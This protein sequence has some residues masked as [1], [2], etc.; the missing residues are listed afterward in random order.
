[1]KKVFTNSI[2]KRCLPYVLSALLL[3]LSY[4]SYPYIR[5]EALAW[6]WMAPMLFALKDVRSFPRFLRNVYLTLLCVAVTGM[7]WLAFS[8]LVGTLLL[9]LIFPVILSVP[10]VVFYFVRQNLGWRVALLSLPFVWTAWDWLYLQT[11]GSL[12]WVPIGVTQSNLYW[13]VQYVDIT[14]VWGISFW[15]VLF[16]VLVILAVDD[17]RLRKAEFRDSGVGRRLL[18][19][20]LLTVFVIM[21]V[22][23]LSYSAFAF[24]KYARASS[25]NHKEISLLMVQPNVNSWDKLDPS[26]HAAVLARTLT[27]T[28][29]ALARMTMPPDLIIWPETAIPGVL[30]ENHEARGKVS[31]SITRWQ[32][33]LL[34]GLLDRQSSDSFS[35]NK[36][37]LNQGRTYKLYNG[38]VMLSPSAKADGQRFNVKSSDMYHKRILMP[39]VERVP[40]VDRIPALEHLA[41]QIGA[42]D[43]VSPGYEATVFS[44]HTRQGDDV[45]IATGICYEGLF[46][47]QMA[48][49]AR[50]GAQMIALIT[51]EGWFSR[52]HGEY[53]LA[54]FSR[55]RSIETRRA[56]ARAA[57]TG[58]TWFVD[59]LGRVQ[60]EAPWWSE[61]QLAGRVIMSDE[62]SLYVRYPDYFPKACAWLALVVFAI[63][64]AQKARRAFRSL[65][66]PTGEAICLD[67][68]F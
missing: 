20:K 62:L 21:L 11:E 51:N 15:L 25:E 59:S 38:A 65:N 5:L 33:P 7:S 39:F 58:I 31:R 29:Q 41:I 8:T 24:T 40:Y 50:N 49:L 52:T 34:T 26:M 37:A 35:G 57:N 4:P 16:N 55:L 22:F 63:T 19:R 60:E 13:L 2:I 54:A 66:I 36:M 9:F 6:F 23:P 42:G 32:I 44:L 56:V 47:T 64:L 17:W 10:L 1:M 67:R 12:A 3:G 14:G 53:Q 61:Q 45:R 27:L 43:G 28:N 30:S 18:I 46:S 48:D 68:K